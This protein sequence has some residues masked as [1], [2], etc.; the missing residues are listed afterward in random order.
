[1]QPPQLRKQEAIAMAKTSITRLASAAVV[2]GITTLA[3]ATPASAMQPPEPV[4]SADTGPVVTEDNGIDWA[5]LG[6]GALGG[7]ALAGAGV[8]AAAGLRHRRHATSP[9]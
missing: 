8:A 1:V 2:T 7:I 6:A 4:G 3:F 9:V 5:P